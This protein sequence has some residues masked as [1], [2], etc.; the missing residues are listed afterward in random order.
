[1]GG[2]GTFELLGLCLRGDGLI[3]RV[4]DGLLLLPVQPSH[5][6]SSV[7]DH[8]FISLTPKLRRGSRLPEL[9]T[10]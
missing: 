8:T 10:L 6:S 2:D 9:V 1:V 7:I 5:P 3:F 4:W